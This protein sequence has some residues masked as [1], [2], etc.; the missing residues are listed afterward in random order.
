MEQKKEKIA[1]TES[2][3]V[4]IDST[5]IMIEKVQLPTQLKRMRLMEHRRGQ[6][7]AWSQQNRVFVETRKTWLREKQF[8][9]SNFTILH[10]FVTDHPDGHPSFFVIVFFFSILCS[11]F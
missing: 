10:G 4:N 8:N 11:S 9:H 1:N 5:L 2:L 6:Q 7:L 3:S